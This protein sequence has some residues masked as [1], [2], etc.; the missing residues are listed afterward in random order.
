MFLTLVVF[1]A[2]MTLLQVKTAN[3]IK[4][5]KSY[6]FVSRKSSKGT[7]FLVQKLRNILSIGSNNKDADK[8]SKCWQCHKTG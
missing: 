4:C 1:H 6:E 8:M 7:D 5:C 3:K 2:Q